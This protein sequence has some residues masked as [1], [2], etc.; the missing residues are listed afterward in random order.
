MPTTI[1][2]KNE[3]TVCVA[4]YVYMFR[5]MNNVIYFNYV[6]GKTTSSFI[7]DCLCGYIMLCNMDIR[8]VICSQMSDFGEIYVCEY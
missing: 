3:K 6:G 5:V 7:Q 4:F 2:Q 8:R 1:H